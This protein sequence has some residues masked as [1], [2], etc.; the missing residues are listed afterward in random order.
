MGS[1][2][3]TGR[4]EMTSIERDVVA[5]SI[6][7][8]SSLST[9]SSPVVDSYPRPISSYGTSAPSIEQTRLYCTRPPSVVWIWWAGT[10][11]LSVATDTRTG[12]VTKPKEMVPLHT[13]R[14]TAHLRPEYP[15]IRA[16]TRYSYCLRGREM[17]DSPGRINQ[18]LESS[19]GSR[20]PL[21]NSAC[22]DNT[23]TPRSPLPGHHRRTAAAKHRG[24]PV[25]PA[26]HRPRRLGRR[27]GCARSTMAMLPQDLAQRN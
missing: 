27:R 2:A 5:G 18:L 10:F 19:K 21:P 3:C 22:P 14:I 9:T 4:N 11:L 13:I 8:S 16:W 17:P 20:S 7:R 12:I 24:T 26:A 15:S 1:T 6:D 23:A 25:Q